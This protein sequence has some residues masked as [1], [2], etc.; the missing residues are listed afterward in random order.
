MQGWL[1]RVA[2]TH[3]LSLARSLA[4]VERED[5]GL[6]RLVCRRES[7]SSLYPPPLFPRTSEVQL[8]R[9]EVS[10]CLFDLGRRAKLMPRVFALLTCW[11]L[12]IFRKSLGKLAAWFF[13]FQVIGKFLLCFERVIY[14]SCALINNY[15]KQF[16]L[17]LLDFNFYRNSE[18]SWVSY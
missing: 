17:T 13:F 6:C 1:A 8:V 5:Q 2:A 14:Y 16:C 3:H 10:L 7:S 12:L 11:D 4:R 9:A 15:N 18:I